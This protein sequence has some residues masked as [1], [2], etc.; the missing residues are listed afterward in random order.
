MIPTVTEETARRIAEALERLAA[1]VEA[2]QEEEPVSYPLGQFP[3]K[4]GGG[5]GRP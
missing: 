2:R 3:E 1:A 4:R 5:R